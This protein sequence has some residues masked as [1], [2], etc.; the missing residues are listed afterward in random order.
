M[1]VAIYPGSFDPITVGH[2]NIAERASRLVDQVIIAVADQNYKNTLFSLAERKA[3]A[4]DVLARLPSCKVITF[5]GLTV[6]LARQYGAKT[7]IRGL[8]AVSDYEYEM[9]VFAINKFLD[10]KL[11]TVFLMSEAEYSFISSSMIKQAGRSGAD[12]SRLTTPMV[13]AALKKRF[14]EGKME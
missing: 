11:E 4:E 5:D 8:R 3:F 1:T 6:A 12:I 9:Q 7:I 13:E 14:M 10:Y 2:I